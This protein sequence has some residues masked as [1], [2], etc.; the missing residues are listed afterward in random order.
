MLAYTC[1]SAII[2]AYADDA[3]GDYAR[4]IAPPDGGWAGYAAGQ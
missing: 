4:D 1:F 2:E 3:Q